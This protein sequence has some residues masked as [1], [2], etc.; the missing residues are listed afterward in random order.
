MELKG[1]Q[2]WIQN[3]LCFLVLIGQAVDWFRYISTSHPVQWWVWLHLTVLEESDI[4]NWRFIHFSHPPERIL[5]I[6]CTIL[7]TRKQCGCTPLWIPFLIINKVRAFLPHR[8][9][10]ASSV[11]K[12]K[13]LVNKGWYTQIECS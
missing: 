5:V 3:R 8:N 2:L 7:A 11:K 10:K 4:S 1:L 13:Y 12:G 6:W 9:S